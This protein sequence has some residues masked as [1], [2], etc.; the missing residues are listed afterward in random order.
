MILYSWLADLIVSVLDVR[1]QA[2]YQMMDEGFIG[3]IFSVFNQDKASKQ[4]R[5]QVTCFQS[6]NQSPEGE[7]PQ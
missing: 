7:A 3:L 1:T 5:F 4:S 2:M 6:I